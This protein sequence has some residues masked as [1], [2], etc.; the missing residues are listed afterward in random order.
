MAGEATTASLVFYPVALG[1]LPAL[2]WLWF[3]LKEDCHPEPR[4]ALLKA[5]VW[6]MIF[7]PIAL[8]LETVV[9]RLAFGNVFQNT[10]VFWLSLAAIEETIKYEAAS[11]S[12]FR[13]KNFD[14]PIDAP[15]YM[16]TAA[17]GFAAVENVFFV[18]KGV[19]GQEDFI[20]TGSLRFFGATLVHIISSGLVGAFLAYAFYK[21]ENYLR[22][23]AIGL[24]LA[25]G[26]HALF[27]FFIIKKGSEGALL[28]FSFVWFFALLLYVFIDRIKNYG[29][30][31]IF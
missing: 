5:F 29:A 20:T 2:L 9:F 8:I 30:S 11:R 17:L 25:I 12:S 21:K 16:I 18:L 22:N 10:L 26:L 19:M 27:N 23:L 3:W 31:I 28:I 13:S 14:E 4:S 15:I 1:F 24:I 7:V 6:G